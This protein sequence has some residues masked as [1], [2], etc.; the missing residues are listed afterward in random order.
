MFFREPPFYSKTLGTSDSN[1]FLHK[2]R[3]LDKWWDIF[4]VVV[5]SPPF[6]LFFVQN[7][8]SSGNI[9]T[10]KVILDNKKVEQTNRF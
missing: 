1:R 3:Q 2:R 6:A 5:F 10:Y 8:V 9:P 7:Y 4:W